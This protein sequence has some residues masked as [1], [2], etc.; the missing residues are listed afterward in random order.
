M[1]RRP[2][3]RS[4]KIGGNGR[5]RTC[6]LS[7][8]KRAFSVHLNYVPELR[9]CE[10]IDRAFPG[11]APWANGMPPFGLSPDWR[12]NGLSLRESPW[13]PALTYRALTD[14]TAVPI[15]FIAPQTLKPSRRIGGSGGN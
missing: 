1:I 9:G 15:F 6:D 8:R 5:T 13:D 4:Q 10:K 14:P 3:T 11:L 7:L 12:N 2:K